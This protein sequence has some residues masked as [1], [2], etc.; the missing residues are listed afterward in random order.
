MIW[1][2]VGIVNKMSNQGL[3]R[4]AFTY[5]NKS[6]SYWTYVNKSCML[7]VY[8]TQISGERLQ[9]WS[10]GVISIFILFIFIHIFRTTIKG[11]IASSKLNYFSVLI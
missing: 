1:K 4:T 2:L 8:K 3:L 6:V 11:I 9:D 10:P 5:Q 7:C